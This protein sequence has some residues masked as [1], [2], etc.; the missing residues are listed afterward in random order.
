M[1]SSGPA[2]SWDGSWS[3]SSSD[4]PARGC[5]LRAGSLRFARS[6]DGLYT[7]A[8]LKRPQADDIRIPGLHRGGVGVRRRFWP[9][10][11]SVLL[12]AGL[13]A[14]PLAMVATSLADRPEVPLLWVSGWSTEL[15]PNMDVPVGLQ[16]EP[17]TLEHL[18]G[19][20][21]VPFSFGS[22]LGPTLSLVPDGERRVLLGGSGGP[23]GIIGRRPSV[24][25]PPA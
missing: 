1:S 5:R 8:M 15:G 11:A 13:L 9:A 17:E 22:G 24:R 3:R 16:P 12:F 23:R 19:S 25:G 6:A 14:G 10:A 18:P 4:P 20:A 2:T 21:V 7:E